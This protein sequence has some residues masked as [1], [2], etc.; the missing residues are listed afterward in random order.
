MRGMGRG[1]KIE[2]WWEG[3]Q[4]R[5]DIEGRKVVNHSHNERVLGQP[6]CNLNPVFWAQIMSENK[7]VTTESFLI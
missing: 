3:D 2:I 6:A 4:L 5:S 7:H 1:G